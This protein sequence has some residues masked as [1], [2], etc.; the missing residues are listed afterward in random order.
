M[1]TTIA[2][3]VLAVTAVLSGLAVVG[4]RSIFR[5]ALAL[6]LC[7]F[8]VA[9]LFVTLNADF[10]AAV[11][12]LIYVGAVAV[13]IILSIMLTREVEHGN[14]SNRMRIPALGVSVSFM[15]VAVFAA[16]GTSWP[17]SQLAPQE[18]TAAVLGNLLFGPQGFVLL[19]EIAGLIILATIIGAISIARGNK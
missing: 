8:A 3:W 5:S 4:L 16:V 9:G 11:Q 15:A 7:F 17:V 1:G 10:L 19:V 2:F 12:V 14:L 6:I 18:E 13:I